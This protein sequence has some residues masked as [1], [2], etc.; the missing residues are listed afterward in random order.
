MSFWGCACA[1][2]WK[3]NGMKKLWLSVLLPLTMVSSV[4][5]A[6]TETED[7]QRAWTIAVEKDGEARYGHFAEYLD[8]YYHVTFDGEI[9]LN[10][11]NDALTALG[12]ESVEDEGSFTLGDAAEGI[13]S[14][15]GM[16]ELALT[17]INADAPDKA[18]KKL[19][20]LGISPGELEQQDL[21]Y[22]AAAMDLGFLDEEDDLTGPLSGE[23]AEKLFY[24][25]AEAGGLARRYIG[26]ISDPDILEAVRQTLSSDILFDEKSLT[27]V[28]EAIVLAGATSGFGLKMEGCNA[29]F[30][31]EYTI[32]YS[33]SDYAHATQLIALLRSEGLDGYVQIEPKISVYEYMI[34]W[35]EP[36]APT[37]TYK[38]LEVKDGRYLCYAV[39]YDL[40]LEFD[41]IEEKKA[42]HGLVERYAKKYDE[43]VD[44]DGNV[45][46]KLLLESWWQPLYS[47]NTEVE[48]FENLIDNVVYDE[49]GLFSIHSF[50]LP[51]NKEMVQ[52]VIR[53]VNADLKAEAVE[54]Y[55]NPAFYRYISGSDYQ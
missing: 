23:I 39:E 12:V 25:S 4:L 51:E 40:M 53:K 41:S 47:S 21:P 29:R 38:V 10:D 5:G 1:R 50:S 43:S 19:E 28:G 18:E 13:V 9:S 52:E 11:F 34:D 49:D 27:E 45:I 33:H 2:I 55:V 24:L 54:I 3:G 6:E 44:A 30:L 17:Y 14:L 48:G 46:E 37:P 16:K 22:I 20:A 7:M 15:A 35:G 8:A 31:D 42:F 26:R 32:K 36:G